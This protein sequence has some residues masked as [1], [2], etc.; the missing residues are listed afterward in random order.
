MAREQRTCV[1]ARLRRARPTPTSTA[2]AGRWRTHQRS[3]LVKHRTGGAP[4][5]GAGGVECS[6][7]A[8]PTRARS[9]LVKSNLIWALKQKNS[10]E[11]RT[12][13]TRDKHRETARP[14]AQTPTNTHETD[15][16]T[17]THSHPVA[18][19]PTP[20]RPATLT[21]TLPL[22]ANQSIPPQP[23]NSLPRKDAR[24]EVLRRQSIP[25][26]LTPPGTSN[27]SLPDLKRPIGHRAQLQTDELP[28]TDTPLCDIAERVGL[29]RTCGPQ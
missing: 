2:R 22:P 28:H 21:P 14:Q 1:E 19:P 7:I 17:D 5:C 18:A 15:T 10:P 8:T 9:R 4:L 24:H 3:H 29:V 12:R 20:T 23:R 6:S 25:P 27:P 11:A 16:N 26:R 13:R